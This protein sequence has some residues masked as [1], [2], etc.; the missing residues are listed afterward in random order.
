MNWSDDEDPDAIDAIVTKMERQHAQ[1]TDAIAVLIVCDENSVTYRWALLQDALAL[2][3]SE[4][5]M[6]S[7]MVD[8]VW[9]LQWSR[10]PSFECPP[11]KIIKHITTVFLHDDCCSVSSNTMSSN[12][13]S[14][15]E[16]NQFLCQ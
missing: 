1:C 2:L 4:D 15:N 3:D 12:T 7:I 10:S 11:G 14:S 9:H 5:D 13:V 16:P 6:K 8:P